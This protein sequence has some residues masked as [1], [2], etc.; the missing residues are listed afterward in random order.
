MSSNTSTSSALTDY[1]NIVDQAQSVELSQA[2]QQLNNNPQE[3]AN[4]L[5]KSKANFTNEVYTQ[6]DNTITKIYGDLKNASDSNNSM[7]AYN[8]RNQEVLKLENQLYQDKKQ[9]AQTVVENKN[10]RER[11]FEINQ[12]EIGNRLDTLFIFQQLFIIMATI[13]ILIFFNKRGIIPNGLLYGISG[14]LIALVALSAIYRY[15]YTR[16]M[17]DQRFWNRRVF[18]GY[19]TPIAGAAGC[20]TGGSILSDLTSDASNLYSSAVAGISSGIS[21]VESGVSG[22]GSDI[23]SVYSSATSDL[24]Q[25][26]SATGQALSSS[27]S[28]SQ[29]SQQTSSTSTNSN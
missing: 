15:R 12:W 21:S 9:E 20:P 3:L 28:P 8:L 16:V 11:Q 26:V 10:N 24:S 7:L 6:K 25:A 4:F 22:L 14:V 23:S 2:L 18:P 1:I 29:N 19:Q 13:V 27:L 5:Q 17:R